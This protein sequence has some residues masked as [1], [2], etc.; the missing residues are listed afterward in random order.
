MTIPTRTQSF[1]NIIILHAN[2]NMHIF[3]NNAVIF[4]PGT[5]FLREVNVTAMFSADLMGTS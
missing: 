5:I 1:D 4:K 3:Y 2:I